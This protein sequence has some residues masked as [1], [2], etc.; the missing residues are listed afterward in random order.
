[1]EAPLSGINISVFPL[2]WFKRCAITLPIFD[3]SGR[4]VFTLA[5]LGL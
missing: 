3:I 1:M 2:A 5:L 4:D